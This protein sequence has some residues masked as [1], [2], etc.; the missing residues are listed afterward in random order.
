M[1]YGKK[2]DVLFFTLLVMAAFC[3]YNPFLLYFQND[4]FVHI[5]LSAQGVLLQHNTFRPV[6]DLSVMMDYGIWGKRAWGYHLTNLMLHVIACII[7]FY[8]SKLM[9]KKYF[10]LQ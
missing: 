2:I 5:P 10:N 4:D 1:F 3:C 7:L 9:L 8:F 6:C